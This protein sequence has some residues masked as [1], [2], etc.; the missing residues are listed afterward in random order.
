L[1]AD[2]SLVVTV[3]CNQFVTNNLA[4]AAGSFTIAGK[5]MDSSSG[6][7]L[8]GIFVQAQTPNNVFFVGG[9]TDTNGNYA[10]G[11]STNNTWRTRPD[12]NAP[13]QIGY[14]ALGNRSNV[15]VTA[16]SVSN[17]NF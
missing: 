16:S 6:A 11:V 2:Q 7:G 12:K 4:V 9:F 14:V 13:A 10:L 8:P 15:V 17:V 3:P 1:I 5:V